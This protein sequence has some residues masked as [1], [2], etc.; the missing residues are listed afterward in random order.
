MTPVEIEDLRQFFGAYFHQ[1]WCLDANEPDQIVQQYLSEGRSL[2]E[3][4]R[5]ALLIEK[6][7]ELMDD[8]SALERA[9]FSD[10]WC[11]YMPSADGLA[12]HA[13]LRHVASLLKATK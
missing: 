5:L 1:D 12:A 4:T 10:L 13:W 9:L 6:Y 2:K 7:A 11:Y 3:L 8:D